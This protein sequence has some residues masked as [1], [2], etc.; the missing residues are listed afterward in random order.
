MSTLVYLG[1]G[2][3]VTDDDAGL[4]YVRNVLS[5]ESADDDLTDNDTD[6]EDDDDEPVDNADDDYLPLPPPTIAN[7][8]PCANRSTSRKVLAAGLGLSPCADDRDI[9]DAVLNFANDDEPA[10]DDDLLIPP[11]MNWAEASGDAEPAYADDVLP[12]PRM[13]Y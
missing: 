12:L 4:G 7:A 3:Y 11:V 5:N 2:E 6:D 10:A 13:V 9:L 8:D 1:L